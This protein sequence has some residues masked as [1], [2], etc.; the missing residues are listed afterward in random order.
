MPFPPY[1]STEFDAAQN[2]TSHEYSISCRQESEPIAG[3]FVNTDPRGSKPNRESHFQKTKTE[4]AIQ[5]GRGQEILDKANAYA[6]YN[7]RPPFRTAQDVANYIGTLEGADASRFTRSSGLQKITPPNWHEDKKRVMYE[8]QQHFLKTGGDRAAEYATDLLA[9]NG[10]GVGIAES[11][12]E[13]PYW[14]IQEDRVGQGGMGKN[15]LGVIH[16]MMANNLAKEMKANG[17]IIVGGK[18]VTQQD[19]ERRKEKIKKSLEAGTPRLSRT[20]RTPQGLKTSPAIAGRHQV[21]QALE[22]ASG[23]RVQPQ[24]LAPPAKGRGPQRVGQPQPLAPPTTKRLPLDRG[25]KITLEATGKSPITYGVSGSTGGSYI[26]GTD[27]NGV[28]IEV[29]ISLSGEITENGKQVPHSEYADW[30]MKEVIQ[31]DLQKQQSRTA[32][33]TTRVPLDR[34]T[35]RTVSIGEKSPITYGVSETGDSYIHGTDRKGAKIEVR[36]SLS[37]DIT[38][39]GKQVSHSEYADWAMEKVIQ[40]NLQKQRSRTAS[41]AYAASW[42]VSKGG[43]SQPLS[44]PFTPPVRKV[45]PSPGRTSGSPLGI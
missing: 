38:E 3:S 24:S 12:S 17:Y 43:G 11:S 15:E 1:S 42:P 36:I 30:A 2:T 5:S 18:R 39:N 34:G 35:E 21:R 22:S 16:Q 14:G 19:I 32:S 9:L 41:A 26:K 13:D 33:T 4:L 31:P 23:R 25:T 20:Q 6:R 27:K 28:N 8:T 45:G 37:G 29:R 40:P 44:P 10:M 7:G